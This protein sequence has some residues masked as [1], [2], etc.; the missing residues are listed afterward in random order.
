MLVH[1]RQSQIFGSPLLAVPTDLASNGVR[2]GE[3]QCSFMDLGPLIPN[4]RPP[5]LGLPVEVVPPHGVV[6][7]PRHP[8]SRPGNTAID[9]VYDSPLRSWQRRR[10]RYSILANYLP[11]LSVLPI[12]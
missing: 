10:H 4:R 1:R 5:T 12:F 2:E 6:N 3:A 7:I 11:L 9:N 8:C